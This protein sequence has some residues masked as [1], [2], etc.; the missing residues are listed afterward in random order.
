MDQFR[1]LPTTTQYA[2]AVMLASITTI[3]ASAMVLLLSPP[4]TYVLLPILFF[5]VIATG[6]MV[7][8]AV[9]ASEQ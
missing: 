7:G 8:I 5:G 9:K 6:A 1:D 2:L 3:L 4:W